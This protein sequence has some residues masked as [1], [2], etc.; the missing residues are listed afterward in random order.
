MI[1]IED[2]IEFLEELGDELAGAGDRINAD[3]ITEVTKLLDDIK[4]L[5][6]PKRIENE[7]DCLRCPNCGH[8]V[9]TKKGRCWD[10]GQRYL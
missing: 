10:C 1:R 6:I 8:L 7:G 4:Q 3:N 9:Y 5:N 2:A